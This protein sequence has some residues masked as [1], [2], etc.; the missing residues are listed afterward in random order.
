MAYCRWGPNSDVYVYRGFSG[1]WWG[2]I[3]RRNLPLPNGEDWFKC[4][5]LEELQQK[6][7]ELRELGYKI[8]DRTFER[9]GKEVDDG[10]LR[11]IE[12]ERI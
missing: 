1:S 2:F 12:R 11:R 9:I 4:S 3:A 7:T 5:S 10:V 8:P 6:L